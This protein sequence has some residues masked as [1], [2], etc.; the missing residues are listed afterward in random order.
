MI[1]KAMGLRVLLVILIAA[2]LAGCS[3]P[4]ATPTAAP[5]P[6]AT[7]LSQPTV[8]L[9]PTL[10]AVQT[11]AVQTYIA[12][13]TKNA[14]T[15]TRVVPTQTL[16]PTATPA[17]TATA[18]GTAVKAT[19]SPTLKPVGPSATPAIRCTVK[20]SYPTAANTIAPGASFNARWVIVNTGPVTWTTQFALAY[21]S[22]ARFENQKTQNLPFNVDPGADITIAMDLKASS[23]PGTYNAVWS[24]LNG[25]Q[26]VCLMGLTVVVK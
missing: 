5:T 22:G 14:P 20:S 9:Q 17:V 8:N 26:P 15:A 2:V 6:A 21:L 3:S 12:N 10:V 16:A 24:V 13:Q 7:Q 23:T 18:Q 4:T 25:F 1:S 11:Q 19:A